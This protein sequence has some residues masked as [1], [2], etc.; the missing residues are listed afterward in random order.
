MSF[1]WTVAAAF[2]LASVVKAPLGAQAGSSSEAAGRAASAEVSDI[3]Y[4]VT[5]DHASAAQRL[6]KVATSFTVAGTGPV[7]LAL[8]EWTPGAYEI[9][10]FA[11]WVVEF[12]ATG[13]GHA[14]AWS[15]QDYD[16]W[17]IDPA[18]AKAITV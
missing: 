10:N 4:D 8:P 15:K 16:T 5:F 18:G 3:R 7:L 12:S 14:L 6:V 9:S 1:R 2:A 13:D 17:R 11:R